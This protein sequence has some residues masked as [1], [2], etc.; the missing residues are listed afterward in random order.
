MI[1]LCKDHHPI[2][3]GG[4]FTVEQL[5]A[6]K[7]NVA[8]AERVRGKFHWLR[9]R[10]LAVVGGNFY[11]ETNRILVLDDQDVIWFTRDEQG[12]LRLN[13][14]MLSLLAQERVV[15]EDN[16]WHNIG[17]PSDL[18]SPPQ[19]KELRIEYPNGDYAQVKFF[20]LQ[21]AATAFE[22]YGNDVL[23]DENVIQYPMT[24]VEVNY[25]I[26]GTT[27]ELTPRGSTLGGMRMTN[28]FMA[29]CGAGV[30]VR[31]G[32]RFRQNPSELPTLPTKR[33]E[34]CTC[35]SGLRFKHCHGYLGS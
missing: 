34:R 12:Y 26:G 5:H 4:A 14:R 25:K 19:G 3:D 20:E 17:N 35:N 6:F 13:V 18:H 15:I 27:L 30:S 22:R 16:I 11:Y 28:G 24:A 10:L 1:A 32:L 21:D 8:E 29:R 9:N 31:T 33:H 23:R 7:G 2:A